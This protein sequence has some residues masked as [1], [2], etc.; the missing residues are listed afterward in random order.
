M[1]VS[2]TCKQRRWSRSRPLLWKRSGIGRGDIQDL[3][4][5]IGV[6]G[7]PCFNHHVL[8]A[9][10]ITLLRERDLAGDALQIRLAHRGRNFRSGGLERIFETAGDRSKSMKVQ[11][12]F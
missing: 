10:D 7:F 4:D 6:G 5:L 3:D 2:N 1:Y 8:G 11:L 9:G 12:S